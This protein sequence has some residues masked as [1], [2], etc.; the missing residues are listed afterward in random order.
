MKIKVNFIA[1]TYLLFLFSFFYSLFKN[2]KNFVN[3]NSKLTTYIKKKSILDDSNMM[4]ISVW[5][6]FSVNTNTN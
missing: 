5:A 6:I 2:F 4:L 1:N 3:I